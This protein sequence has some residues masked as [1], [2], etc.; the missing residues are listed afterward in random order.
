VI[1]AQIFR[2]LMIAADLDSSFARHVV[3][4]IILPLLAGSTTRPGPPRRKDRSS[5]RVTDRI[6]CW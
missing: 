1:E 2:Q 3:D 4:D 5:N 6:Q